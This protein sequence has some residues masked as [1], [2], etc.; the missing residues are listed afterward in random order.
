MGQNPHQDKGIEKKHSEFI[1]SPIQLTVTKEVEKEVE[2]DEEA[3]ED[4]AK[5]EEVD[6]EDKKSTK[7]VKGKVVENEELNKTGRSPAGRQRLV[8]ASRLRAARKLLARQRL[9]RR[10]GRPPIKLAVTKEVEKEVE[11]DEEA[12]EDE[13]R[14][15]ETV[16]EK[17]VENEELNKTKHFGLARQLRASTARCPVRETRAASPKRLASTHR[18]PVARGCSRTA[19]RQEEGAESPSRTPVKKHS[20]FIAS[21]IQ[22]AVTNGG[23]EGGRGRRGGQG[24]RGQ[25]RREVDDEDKNTTKTVKE[26]VVENEELNKTKPAPPARKLLAR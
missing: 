24:V 8:L 19:S 15:E 23:R 3:K 18:C 16:K 14:I 17:V 5:I 9:A 13:A 26:K 11:D 1:A 6:D 2:D 10:R 25:D 12:K 22:L 21:A 7:T 4:E 20:E